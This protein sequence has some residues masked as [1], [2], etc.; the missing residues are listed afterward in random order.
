MVPGIP[1]PVLSL[2]PT[3]AWRLVEGLLSP[4]RFT[5]VNAQARLARSDLIVRRWWQDQEAEK[6][7]DGPK[8]GIAFGRDDPLLKDCKEVLTDT[9]A[10]SLRQDTNLPAAGSWI[11]HAGHYPVEDRPEL[12]TELLCAFIDT[13]EI[14]AY[15]NHL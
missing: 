2:R 7:R 14:Q 12:V 15:N 11:D 1:D 8:V 10:L 5:N 4:T 6:S 9:I 3:T 13:V